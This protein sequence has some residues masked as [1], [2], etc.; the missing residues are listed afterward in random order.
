MDWNYECDHLQAC[1]VGLPMTVAQ[2]LPLLEFEA[3]KDAFQVRGPP[4]AISQ[5]TGMC[6]RD[7]CA[8]QICLDACYW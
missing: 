3:R 2:A 6:E 1:K 8:T 4:I 5:G 7:A